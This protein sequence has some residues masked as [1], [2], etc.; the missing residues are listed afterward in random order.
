M[1]DCEL[2]VKYQAEALRLGRLL[3]LGGLKP[4]TNNY[5]F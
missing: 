5:L 4:L 2:F 3:D 1:T